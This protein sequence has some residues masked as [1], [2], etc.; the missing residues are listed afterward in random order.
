MATQPDGPVPNRWLPLI[1]GVL[2]NTVMGTFYA[3][4]L[5]IEPLEEEFDWLR[6]QTSWTFSIG[7]VSIAVWFVVAGRLH[8]RWGFRPVAVLG[9]LL[10]SLGFFLASFTQSLPWLY[11][12][13][14]ALGGA[15]NGF[16]YSVPIP[17]ISKWFPDK[18]GLAL[19]IA[20]GGYGAGAGIFGPIADRLIE[21]IGWQATFRTLGFVFFAIT[22]VGAW[23]L[24]G[25]AEGYQPPGWDA[26]AQAKVAAS[27]SARDIPTGEML[28]TPTFYRLWVAYFFG[29]MAGLGLISQLVPFGTQAG[30]GSVV[31]IGLVAGSLGNVS[32]RI[33]SGW[34]S[35]IFGRLNILRLMVL[36]SAIAMS[37]LFVSGS[38]I[39][40]F[41]AGVFVV[42]YC[43]GTLLAVFAATSADF[44]GTKY[45][46]TNYGLLFLA[47]GLSALVAAPVAGWVYDTFGNYQYAFFGAA[48]LSLVALVSLLLVQ[49]PRSEGAPASP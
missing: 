46:G 33:L 11:I 44:Y 15:G 1:G 43:Y 23:L 3:W 25:P 17:V 30:I 27:R 41:V 40:A 5:F 29:S 19:G 12:V 2:M 28:R 32:G 47:W 20:I 4:S 48:G 38:Q 36:V 39:L 7:I 6:A 22:M 8:N 18:R 9:G 37:L 21:S 42:Y 35:D 34:M 45:L 26:A 10:F 16:G 31:L 13:F 49:T 14:G 24:K